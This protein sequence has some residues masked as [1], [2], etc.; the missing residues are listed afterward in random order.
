MIFFC[1]SSFRPSIQQHM[2]TLVLR[3]G[4]CS[5]KYRGGFCYPL[6]W[7]VQAEVIQRGSPCWCSGSI[8]QPA[9]AA[10]LLL[11]DCRPDTS[12]SM[13]IGWC[14]E[15]G[16][17]VGNVDPR[18]WGW[19]GETITPNVKQ[20]KTRVNRR[21]VKYCVVD[22][23][24]NPSAVEKLGGGTA[25]LSEIEVMNSTRLLYMTLVPHQVRVTTCTKPEIPYWSTHSYS[26][27]Q[28]MRE[29]CLC[30]VDTWLM[31]DYVIALI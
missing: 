4:R 15:A 18:H 1:L 22:V 9:V 14:A 25:H 17:H 8:H 13:I 21:W 2:W 5:Y 7:L 10:L 6:S 19:R 31:S 26:E 28:K 20:P 30:L 23:W 3:V 24:L 29:S 11:V 16:A 12:V 27:T